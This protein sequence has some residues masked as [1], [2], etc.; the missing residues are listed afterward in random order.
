MLYLLDLAGT[1]VF[2][3]T[4]ALKAARCKLDFLGVMI[5]AAITGV[6]GGIM[7]DLVLGDAPPAV[8]RDETYLIVA[9]LTGLA[10]FF[11]SPHIRHTTRT[12]RLSDAM[13]LALFTVIGA[14]KGESFGLG[15]VGVLFAGTITAVG[16]GVIRDMMVNEIPA[17]ISR[18]LYATAA[19]A[20]ALVLLLI[21]PESGDGVRMAAGGGAVLA[22][23]LAA[24]RWNLHLPRARPGRE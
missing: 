2:A 21:P 1:A 3:L 8:F 9:L 10:G 14:L 12:I 15:P 17:V 20:G 24:I 13:G 22:I 19:A 7:R 23:R 6:G 16:G 5:L 11:L 4:G 18:E